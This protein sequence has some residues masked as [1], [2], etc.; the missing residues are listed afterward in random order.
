MTFEP[1]KYVVPGYIV[2]GLTLF[3]GKPKIGKSW[4][5]L[6]VA[7][8]VAR[9]GF[10]LG[11]IHCQ[12]GDV[13]YCAL[14]D[15]LRRLRSRMHKL[16]GQQ[17]WP[18]RLIFRTE[19]P[20]LTEGGL[21]QIKEWIT[22]AANPRLIIIDTFAMVR[23][24]QKPGENPYQADYDAVKELR[25]LA[26][27]LG[28]AIV[29]VHHL[30]KAEADDVFDTVSGTLGLTGAPDTIL[31]L[32]RDTTGTII[33]HGRGRDLIEVEKA[34][35]FNRDACTWTIAGEVSAFRASGERQ[36]ILDAIKDIGAP[37]TP[38]EIAAIAR[39]KL[40]NVRRLLIK[41]AK[42]GMVGKHGYGKYVAASAPATTPKSPPQ[43]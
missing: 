9:A 11:E 33:L 19:M 18:K 40:V 10:T 12:E 22:A 21:A 41:M 3:A 38:T 31:V 27:Q 8:A 32:R 28:I 39:L 43:E 23:T 13:L 5:L 17:P 29:L 20:R 1:I 2:E 16:L 25:D 34:L 4:L 35:T 37:A 7:I 36:A 26:S 6:H 30:R 24:P 42:D 15:N 14:E